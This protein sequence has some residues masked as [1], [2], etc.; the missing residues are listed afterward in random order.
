[1]EE[2]GSQV[3]GGSSMR[4][5]QSTHC[6]QEPDGKEGRG[7]RELGMIAW[8]RPK[9]GGSRREI[10]STPADGVNVRGLRFKVLLEWEG[11]TAQ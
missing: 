7:Q 4:M 8:R 10:P 11:H 6:R 2:L 3:L 9:V 1:M 5:L